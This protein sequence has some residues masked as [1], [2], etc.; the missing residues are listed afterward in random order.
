MASS[1]AAS[2]RVTDMRL[3]LSLAGLACMVTLMAATATPVASQPTAPEFGEG[4]AD[5]VELVEHRERRNGYSRRYHGRY[6]GPYYGPY[7]GPYAYYGPY[8]GPYYYPYYYRPYYGPSV[9][10]SF[11]F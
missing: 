2:G 1:K 3:L 11:G 5:S 10:F 4:S 9:S 6:D 7:P 8:Y